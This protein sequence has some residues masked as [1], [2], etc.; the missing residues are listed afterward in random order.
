MLTE[1]DLVLG[2]GRTLH[3]YDTGRGSR[4]VFW[5][6]GTPNIGAPPQPLFAE[7]DRLDVRWIGYDRPGYG[8]S[9]P[10]PGRD[11][12]SAAGDVAAVADALGLDAFGVVGH[13]GGAPHALAGAAL[14]GDRVRAA[15]AISALAPYGAD[16]LDWFAGMAPGGVAALRAAVAGRAAKEAY[17]RDAGDVDPGFTAA[18]RDALKTD[19]SWFLTVVEPALAAGP[20]PVV[21]DDLAYVAPWGFDPAT[22][23]A[24]T[25]LL[26]GAE[27]RVAPAA[28]AS[29]LA[30]HCPTATLRVEPG[31][32]HVSIMRSAASALRLVAAEL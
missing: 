19:W 5:L 3:V 11:I 31:Q 25:L 8:A 21:D 7:A 26:H 2:D 12:A 28:H 4:P 13:S 1:S 20:A 17:E 15:A 14:L 10:R 32:G 6:H 16:G 24:P 23:A 22:I 27:D 30:G 29:W 9:T 18:D